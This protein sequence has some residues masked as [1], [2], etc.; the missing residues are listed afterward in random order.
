MRSME[1][2]CPAGIGNFGQVLKAKAEGI[3]PDLPHVNIVAVKQ[4]KCK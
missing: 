2:T 1:Y 4:S 3:V